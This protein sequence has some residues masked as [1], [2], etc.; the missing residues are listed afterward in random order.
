MTV[1]DYSIK[2]RSQVPFF[3]ADNVIPHLTLTDCTLSH[4]RGWANMLIE[5]Y[6]SVLIERTVITNSEDALDS[7]YA[8][9]MIKNVDVINCTYSH[10]LCGRAMVRGAL[11]MNNS[12]LSKS[13]QELHILQPPFSFF[14]AH[15]MYYFYTLPLF[16]LYI[17]LPIFNCTFYY[18]SI[19]FSCCSLSSVLPLFV[20]LSLGTRCVG[21]VG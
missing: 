1:I 7:I 20:L 14:T 9:I 13:D 19:C 5:G 16:H 10:L 18:I 6:T 12:S 17:S 4:S 3:F 15:S 8:D 11:T 2:E 21:R